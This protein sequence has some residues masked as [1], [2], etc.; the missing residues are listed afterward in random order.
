MRNRNHT[1]HEHCADHR[2]PR[3]EFYFRRHDHE[4]HFGGPPRP[5]DGRRR[6]GGP[7]R[8]F[9]SGDLRFVILHLIQ[10]SPRHGY[11]II[12][13]IQDKLGGS[14]APSPGIIYPMLTMLEEMGQTTVTTEGT[15]KLYS[16][17]PEGARVL[18][19]NKAIVD[20][21]FARMQQAGEQQSHERPPQIVRAVENLRMVLKM[22]AGNLTPEQINAITDILD[23]A[24]KKIER[25]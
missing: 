2:G 17:T 14:Y 24:S 16:I 3:F 9:Q 20:V 11:E 1:E 25:A 22:R 7:G 21:I 13:S 15:R 10:E 23:D 19:E 5:F 6:G 8:L 4:G 12:K 18:A